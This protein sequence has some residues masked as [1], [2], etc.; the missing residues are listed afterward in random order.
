MKDVDIKQ[1]ETKIKLRRL[2]QADYE[3]VIEL[4]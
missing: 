2:N 3:A 4:Q 1:F